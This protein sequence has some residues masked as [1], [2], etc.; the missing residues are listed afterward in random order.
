[1]PIVPLGEY[2]D[3]NGRQVVNPSGFAGFFIQNRVPN[4]SGDVRIEYM[5]EDIVDVIGF[6][7]NETQVTNVVTPVLYR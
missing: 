5:A 3:G 2:T 1:M 6:D 4:G 7:P